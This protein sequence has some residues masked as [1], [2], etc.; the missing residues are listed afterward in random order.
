MSIH[1]PVLSGTI[2]ADCMLAGMSSSWSRRDPCCSTVL[3]FL[4]PITVTTFENEK[5]MQY[6]KFGRDGSGK[7]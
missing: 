7:D 3:P 5:K 6:T 4:Q 1:R 2:S